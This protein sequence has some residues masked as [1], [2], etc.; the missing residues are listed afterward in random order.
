MNLIINN[1][2]P[3]FSAYL[4]GTSQSVTVTTFTKATLD[5]EVFDT[6]NCFASSRF[7]PNVAGYYYISG[8][9]RATSSASFQRVIVA[10]FKNGSEYARV[11]EVNFS[12]GV[13]TQSQ[14]GG[15]V[16]MYLNGSTDYVELYGYI[17][18]TGTLTF[19]NDGLGAYSTSMTGSLVRAA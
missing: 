10:L 19:A 16:I 4:S 17:N 7:T 3:A 6:A 2:V 18:G 1:H 15:G 9:I 11:G 5:A 14:L 12:S 8:V 13:I